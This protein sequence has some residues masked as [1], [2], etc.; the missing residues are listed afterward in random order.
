M[1]PG[2]TTVRDLENEGSGYAQVALGDAM[3]QGLINGPRMHEQIRLAPFEK[4]T[5]GRSQGL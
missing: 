5:G 3:K 4:Y 1:S 2:R